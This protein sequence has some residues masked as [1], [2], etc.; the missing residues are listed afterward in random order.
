MRLIHRRKVD[1]PQPEGPMS[2]VT[3]WWGQSRL[4]DLRA[5]KSP[6]Q[7]EKSWARTAG[8]AA[9]V[10][11][12]LVWASAAVM[13]GLGGRQVRGLASLRRMRMAAAL[14]SRRTASSTMMPAAA[15][16]MKRS[17]GRVVQA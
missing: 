3:R 6:Y 9:S 1:F 12:A 7:H 2:A 11:G 5:W 10:V 4:M 16:W 15:T 13:V 17:S 14:N 8:A